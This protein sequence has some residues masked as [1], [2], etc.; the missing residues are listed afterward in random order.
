M[1]PSTPLPSMVRH[2]WTMAR[3]AAA[4]M[5][6]L[7]EERRRTRLSLSDGF[8]FTASDFLIKRFYNKKSSLRWTF[9]GL[10]GNLRDDYPDLG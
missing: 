2:A 8:S 5:S 4:T 6:I 3:I 7:P 10:F 1:N 9:H